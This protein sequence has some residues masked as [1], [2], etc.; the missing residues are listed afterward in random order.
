MLLSFLVII[1]FAIC[2]F[3]MKIFTSVTAKSSDKPEEIFK[4][5]FTATSVVAYFYVA[6]TVISLFASSTASIFSVTVANLY[7]IFLAVFAYLGFN[8]TFYLLSH[9]RSV[10]FAWILLVGAILFLGPFTVE[11]LSFV[12]VFYSVVI[13]KFSSG[14]GIGDDRHDSQDQ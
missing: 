8:F 2:G 5:R 9:R 4:W 14:T 10:A 1:S 6:L 13:N 3:S 11:I 12:G 7:N